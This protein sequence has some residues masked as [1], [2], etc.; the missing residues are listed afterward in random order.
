[1]NAPPSDLIVR[2]Q[3]GDMQAFAALV[4]STQT[5]VYNL[6]YS[7]LHSREEAED[8]TQETFVRV[9]RA[10]PGFRAEAKFTTW[11]YRIT[12]NT[13]LNRRRQ[14]SA[15]MAKVDGQT[16]PESV[17]IPEDEPTAATL[18]DE[19]SAVLWRAVQQLPAKYRL[20]ISL[21][22]Q[23]QLSYPEIARTLALPLG[24]IKAHLNRARQSLAK[25]LRGQQEG[26]DDPV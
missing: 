26:L 6:A 13:C 4:Q 21:F 7:L 8:L 2:A 10:L 1:M 15:E 11:L 3:E 22:Y 17:S 9:W 23:Q 20:V 16:D 19:R 14:L 24:T 25:S 5:G 12:V 18:R